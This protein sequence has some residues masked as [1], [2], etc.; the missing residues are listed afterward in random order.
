MAYSKVI[1]RLCRGMKLPLFCVSC[2]DLKLKLKLKLKLIYD[3]RSVGQSVLVSGSHLEPMARFFSVLYW[4]LLVSCCGELSLTRG[5]ICNLIVQL[6]L[7]LARAV[8][9]GT[10]SRRT[11]TIFYCLIWHSPNLEG[12]VPVFMSP[13]NR[14]AQLYP[15]GTDY[16][17]V[18]SYEMSGLWW[19]YSNRPPLELWCQ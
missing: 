19:R 3:R 7:G 8:T 1:R 10:N 4:Q 6:L 17:S 13:R 9:L 5:W 16:I 18:A 12:Q 11:Q 2:I 15:P 14:V